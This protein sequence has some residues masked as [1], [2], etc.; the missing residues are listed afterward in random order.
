MYAKVLSF[1]RRHHYTCHD[2][3]ARFQLI[4]SVTN[5]KFKILLTKLTHA[6]NMDSRLFKEKPATVER[7]AKLSLCMLYSVCKSMPTVVLNYACA[8]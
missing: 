1:F 6:D 5:N 8:K 4:V 3:T 2:I 7:R